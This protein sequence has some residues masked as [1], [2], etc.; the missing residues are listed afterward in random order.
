[1]ILKINFWMKG[2]EEKEEEDGETGSS[3]IS[4]HPKS[5]DKFKKRKV[6]DCGERCE[7]DRPGTIV[8]KIVFHR[9][10]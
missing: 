8:S 2:E 9:E 5:S 4:H 7:D 1:M 6:K 3:G 10:G